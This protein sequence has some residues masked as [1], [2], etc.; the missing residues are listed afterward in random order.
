MARTRSPLIL[1]APPI[2][3]LLQY[4]EFRERAIDAILYLLEVGN[5]NRKEAVAERE[6]KDGKVGRPPE[7]N[8]G[9]TGI[10]AGRAG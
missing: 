2:E 1:R 6:G 10:S 7:R 5:E 3:E 8:V 4:P 9:E